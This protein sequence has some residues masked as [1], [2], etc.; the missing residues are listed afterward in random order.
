MTV[1]DNS[2]FRM[3]QNERQD[4]RVRGP[5]I[6]HVAQAYLPETPL[7]QDREWKEQ[8]IDTIKK[9]FV[10]A[11]P[12]AHPRVY[13]NYWEHLLLS[14]IYSRV[15]S[16]QRSDANISPIEAEAIG[17][18]HDLGRLIV[19]HRYYRNDIV[20]NLI[21][22]DL[23]TRNEFLSKIP[24]MSRILGRTNPVGGIGDLS[25]AQRIIDVG[26]NLGKRKPDG[27]FFGIE[28]ITPYAIRQSERYRNAIFPSERWGIHQLD[29]GGRQLFSNKLLQDEIDWMKSR[30]V[31]FDF[32]MQKAQE[33]F[34]SRENQG[35]L[36]AV[37][38]AQ[39]TLDPEVD[40]NLQR[41][42]IKHIVFDAGGVLLDTSDEE[43]FRTL[44]SELNVPS[45]LIGKAIDELAD[46]GMAAEITEEDY[47]IRFFAKINVDFTGIDTA[48]KIFR[49]PQI[50][51]PY[52]GMQELVAEI[53]RKSN[54]QVYV[55]SDAIALVTDTVMRRILE[56]YPSF[57]PNN[58][59]ISSKINASK[60][61]NGTNAFKRFL[62]LS[63]IDS[64]ESTL[65]IDDN[66][67]YT[68]RARAE[69]GMRSL[70]FRGAPYQHLE[71]QKRL[72]LE[73]KRAGVI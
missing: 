60:R 3:R 56:F 68:T 33:I 51:K 39:E 24:P 30:G 48:K 19:P 8:D 57:D 55:L 17:L 16:A 21:F 2:S 58:I 42:Q 6:F 32:T 22:R 15:F 59:F 28:D 35:W 64:P 38:D 43:L 9:F 13:P 29:E 23:G 69:N 11:A 61:S 71:A 1:E 14:S 12:Y 62:E 67:S 10:D 5:L 37:K 31:D 20:E 36:F 70:T 72:T 7:V 66:E 54:I 65:L 73:L 18:L 40:I 46:I 50:Y 45:E 25:D 41:P 27:S 47:L 44:S 52:P 63:K 4:V 53:G 26:D 49:K 34:G